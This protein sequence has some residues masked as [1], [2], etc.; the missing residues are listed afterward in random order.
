MKES[1]ASERLTFRLINLIGLNR[2]IGLPALL[3]TVRQMYCQ[4]Y[5]SDTYVVSLIEILPV[6]F[7]SARYNNV[8]PYSRESVSIS[9]VRAACVRLAQEIL[10]NSQDKNA[11]LIKIME[12]AKQDALPEVRFAEITDD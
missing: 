1:P 5:L 7:D 10:R 11:E 4:K 2:L 6:I 8:S 3:W 12:K 9:I